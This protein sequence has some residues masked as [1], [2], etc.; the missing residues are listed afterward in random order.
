ML[1]AFLVVDLAFFSGSLW[2]VALAVLFDPDA[3]G[4]CGRRRGIRGRR[5]PC[6]RGPSPAA[7]ELG[8]RYLTLVHDYVAKLGSTVKE[9]SI[10]LS[11][12]ATI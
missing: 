10:N 6:R 5:G 7:F 12:K 2:E 4:G 8:S 3:R 1:T 9:N 11:R